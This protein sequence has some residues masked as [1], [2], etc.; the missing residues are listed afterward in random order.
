MC[1]RNSALAAPR[2][3][4]HELLD[5]ETRALG[6]L[7]EL[8]GHAAQKEAS[9]AAQSA[10]PD[11]YQIYAVVFGFVLLVTVTATLGV[12]LLSRFLAF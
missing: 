3:E 11:G 9:Q 12:A 10:R 5:D 2:I 4:R 1:S 6:V 7:D 8:A